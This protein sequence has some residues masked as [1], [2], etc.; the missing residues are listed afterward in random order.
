[1]AAGVVD[2]SL[3]AKMMIAS[4]GHMLVGNYMMVNVGLQPSAEEL[5]LGTFCPYND[6]D[7]RGPVVVHG[8]VV[9]R[10]GASRFF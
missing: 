7:P 10:F 6:A 1:M 2:S 4:Y 9:G 8:R 3:M 5:S